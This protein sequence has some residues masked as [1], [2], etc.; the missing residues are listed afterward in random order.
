MFTAFFHF[1][2]N[3]PFPPK[4]HY[5][6]Y[7]ILREFYGILSVIFNNQE[8]GFVPIFSLSS[9][10][11]SFNL[12]RSLFFVY[13]SLTFSL[14]YLF[15]FSVS[16]SNVQSWFCVHITAATFSPRFDT[17]VEPSIFV[18]DRYF[19]HTFRDSS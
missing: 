3:W 19:P 4:H 13:P 9:H 17:F 12:M 16:L 11:A 8:R 1:G 5:K 10:T 7:S 14:P 15:S 6:T 2:H 18:Y